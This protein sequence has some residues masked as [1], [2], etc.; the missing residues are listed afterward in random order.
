MACHIVFT[1]LYATFPI[2]LVLGNRNQTTRL[3]GDRVNNIIS[4]ILTRKSFDKL[5][6]CVLAF[7]QRPNLI[8]TH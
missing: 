2:K 5:D 4:F 6:I 1:T 7:T 3:I 8:I